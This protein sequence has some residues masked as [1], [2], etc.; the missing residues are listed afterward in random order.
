MLT[1]KVPIAEESV[2]KKQIWK[3]SGKP[4][5]DMQKCCSVVLA[6]FD[7]NK[8]YKWTYKSVKIL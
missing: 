2:E 3:E 4:S 8:A 5:R 1:T 6:G 7:W